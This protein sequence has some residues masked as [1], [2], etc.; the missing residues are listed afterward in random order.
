M[1]AWRELTEDQRWERFESLGLPEEVK[2]LCR[3][4]KMEIKFPIK[5][6][7]VVLDKLLV[8]GYVSFTI[9]I[10]HESGTAVIDALMPRDLAPDDEVASDF[11]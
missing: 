9:D 1:G 7:H 4:D 2:F 6:L 8:A 10:F 5:L 3:A 11:I